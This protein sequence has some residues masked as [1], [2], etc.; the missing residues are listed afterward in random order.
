M[1]LVMYVDDIIIAV[2]SGVDLRTITKI[3]KEKSKTMG[4]I[5]N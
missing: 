2:Q 5:I 4:F 1:I 3:L